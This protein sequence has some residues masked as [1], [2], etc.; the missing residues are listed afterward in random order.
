MKKGFFLSVILVSCFAVFSGCIKSTPAVTTI[1]PSL[2]ATIGTYN[3]TALTVVPSTLDTQIHDSTTTLII[4]AKTSDITAKGDEIVLHITKYKG[5]TGTFSVIRGEASAFYYH[6]GIYSTAFGD[7]GS[8]GIIS[9]THVTSNSI[10]GYF[11]FTTSD[12]LY[13]Q[14]GV[15]TVGKP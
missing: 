15:F 12:G 9:I 3:F 5:V 13:V 10:V 8:S 7:S 4:T 2:T 1:D 11:V 6:N 14:N